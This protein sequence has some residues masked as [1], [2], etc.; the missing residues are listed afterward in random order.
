MNDAGNATSSMI[1][2]DYTVSNWTQNIILSI[3]EILKERGEVLEGED[4]VF[5]SGVMDY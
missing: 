1:N 2:L 3:M 4:I 5:V